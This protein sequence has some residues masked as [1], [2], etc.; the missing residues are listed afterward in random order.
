MTLDV[1]ESMVLNSMKDVEQAPSIRSPSYED[2]PV[3]Q[4][5]LAGMHFIVPKRTDTLGVQATSSNLIEMMNKNAGYDMLVRSDLGYD[6]T[7]SLRR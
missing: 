4:E 1:A 6:D 7:T 3:D 2:K 5:A